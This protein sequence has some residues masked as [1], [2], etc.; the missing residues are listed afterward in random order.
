VGV[1]HI[2]EV[3]PADADAFARW[4]AALHAGESEERTA[5]LVSSLDELRLSLG[6]P[7]PT[8]TRL[9]VG[10]WDG[11]DCVGALLLELPQRSDLDTAEV[12]I[13]VP[14]AHRRCGTGDALWRW[15]LARSR[16]EGRPVLQAELAVP[17][18][19]TVE[20]W[21]G[22]RFATARGFVSANVEDH[23]VVGL[24]Y[25]TARLTSLEAAAPVDDYR[26][27]AWV[28]PCLEE[29]VEAWA[30]LR[31]TMSADVPTGELTRAAVQVTA[32]E[33]RT[34]DARL[35]RSYVTLNALAVTG[36]REPV[37][38]SRVFLPRTRPADVQQDDTLVLHAHRGHGL[39]ARMKTANLRSLAALP[40]QHRQ[41][42]RWL[43]TYTEQGNVPMQAV[44]ARFGFRRVEVLHEL[45]RRSDR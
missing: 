3:P 17:D 38:Y 40:A 1:S 19:H 4:H 9:A 37:G 11:I 30:R 14:P 36:D 13:A 8:K 16:H 22:G 33:V 43:H 6:S 44:N 28:G 20:T 25:D 32:D 21:P 34:S 27:L 15:A 35:E 45:E 42:R 39:G 23:L 10:A 5:A 12:S 26:V 29:H 41:Q 24:P 7:S 2:R 31:T 18:G